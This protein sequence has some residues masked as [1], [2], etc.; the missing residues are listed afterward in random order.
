MLSPLLLVTGSVNN[1]GCIT[2]CHKK[3]IGIKVVI[4]NITFYV[5]LAS[6]NSLDC[7][8][9][10]FRNFKM[11][12]CKSVLYCTFFKIN[13]KIFNFIL[14]GRIFYGYIRYM[15]HL[16]IMALQKQNGAS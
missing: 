12:L 11:E 8:D 14:I 6:E 16:S 9:F 10:Q 15:S 2:G 5:L 3:V 1:V 4:D 13:L 7:W